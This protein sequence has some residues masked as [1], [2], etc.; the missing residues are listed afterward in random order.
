MG[1]VDTAAPAARD[2]YLEFFRSLGLTN[3]TKV[4]FLGRQ[5]QT[6]YEIAT[7]LDEHLSPTGAA[8]HTAISRMCLPDNPLHAPHHRWIRVH[9]RLGFFS[10]EDEHSS[11]IVNVGLAYA[12]RHKELDALADANT[13][14]LERLRLKA[15]HSG[16]GAPP[17]PSPPSCASGD[18]AEVPIGGTC[19]RQDGFPAAVGDASTEAGAGAS[20]IALV[21]T[22]G[23]DERGGTGDEDGGLDVPLGGTLLRRSAGPTAGSGD[24]LVPDDGGLVVARRTPGDASGGRTPPPDDPVVEVM[25][26]APST[27]VDSQP[28]LVPST[29]AIRCIKEVLT[30]VS[31]RMDAK[32]V[33]RRLLGDGL[34]CWARLHHSQQPNAGEAEKNNLETGWPAVRALL[35]RYWPTWQ[36]ADGEPG[37]MPP[38]G[39][40]ANNSHAGRPTHSGKWAIAVDMSAVNPVICSMATKSQRYFKKGMLPEVVEVGRMGAHH[41]PPLPTTVACMLVVGTWEDA[42]CSVLKQ[43]ALAGRSPALL[44]SPLVVA[45]CHNFETAGL[46]ESATLQHGAVENN[47]GS[48]DGEYTGDDSLVGGSG[49]ASAGGAP[50]ADPPAQRAESQWEATK[51]QRQ[52]EIDEL[53]QAEKTAQVVASRAKRIEIRRQSRSSAESAPPP[54][55]ARPCPAVDATSTLTP[56]AR[57]RAAGALPPRPRVVFLRVGPT[58]SR[59]Q[60][61]K[62]AKI[63][64]ADDSSNGSTPAGSASPAR[65]ARTS[66]SGASSAAAHVGVPHALEPPSALMQDGV[67][68]GPP[69]LSLSTRS[70]DRVAPSLPSFTHSMIDSLVSVPPVGPHPVGASDSAPNRLPSAED[71]Q[72]VAASMLA[73]QAS[74][75]RL[76]AMEP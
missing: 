28:S 74:V 35:A 70:V 15:T 75:S 51:Q 4:A 59:E 25:A 23:D 21:N 64:P 33:L 66:S 45:A 50:S 17:N 56:A 26:V 61:G 6:F 22:G 71:R 18:E 57:A 16:A 47:D 39:S 11:R 73:S 5:L 62:R 63:A 9:D 41:K 24:D 53:L 3:H 40:V 2:E 69:G 37:R 1:S 55:R 52:R 30:S 19:L 49:A 48:D 8:L 67:S 34:L 10:D 13:L 36:V 31:R 44:V 7:T 43:L 38:V 42:F 58:S 20:G 12:Y 27:C 76:T 54:A 29:T 14:Q 68:G 60:G 65:K 72:P 46:E 32:D